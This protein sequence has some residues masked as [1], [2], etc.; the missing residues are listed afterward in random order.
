MTSWEQP[1]SKSQL[2]PVSSQSLHL[3]DL[4]HFTGTKLAEGGY[5]LKEIMTHMGHDTPGIALRYLHAS[6]KR[7]ENNHTSRTPS[8]GRPPHLVLP[9]KAT[10]CPSGASPARARE[11]ASD[12]QRRRGSPCSTP[13]SIG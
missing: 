11:G 8:S 7:M 5:E 6:K 12:P 4:R 13:T 1:G 3:H 9:V 10:S 2:M